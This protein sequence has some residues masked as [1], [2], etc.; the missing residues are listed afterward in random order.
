[1]NKN[2]ENRYQETLDYIY[3]FVDNSMTHQQNLSPENFDLSRV[4]SF[5]EL[6]GNPQLRYPVIHVAGSKGKGSVCALCA[7]A[8][9]AQGYKVG[10][11]TSP[12]LRDFEERIQI[13][14]QSISRKD[15]VSLTDEIKKHVSA[16][17]D[18]TT[19][20]IATALGFWYFARQKVD[21]AI[22][23]VGL[24]GRLDATNVVQP[25]VTVITT[26][27][28]EHTYIL[29]DTLA[30]IAAEKGGIIKH[31]IPIVL[32][33]QDESAQK[34]VVSI[35][36][37]KKAPLIE[38]GID[39][40]Y[41]Q[42]TASLDGQT[43]N[44]GKDQVQINLQIGLLGPHQID[45]AAVAYTALITARKAGLFVTDAA[46]K[47]GFAQAAWPG[48]FEVLRRDP[49]L[50]VDAAHTPGAIV[51]LVETLDQFFPKQPVILIFGVSEDKNIS[52]MISALGPRVKKIICAQAPH[53]R[54]MDSFSLAQRG[55]ALGLQ[56]ESI[57][58]TGDALKAAFNQS[59][60]NDVVLVTGSIFIAAC[61]RIA[62][63][64]RNDLEQ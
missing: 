16:I 4:Y 17:P 7:V 28:L 48:R 40:P 8:L 3:S 58:N 1:M 56:T 59:N 37:E 9:E 54:A 15:F 53:P 18:L 50:I 57:P 14:G 36:S 47:K 39:V 31:N 26:L 32:A 25:I 12:H 2:L 21:V 35:A 27:L 43:F 60:T 33:R 45:N 38:V 44:I 52:G 23:E 20:E 34:V 63:F 29:G 11:Y 46:I 62:W 49:P 41:H 55:K 30:E 13:N 10:L 22:I 5:M 64:E 19:F 24:G 42:V 51:R 6:L 61:A